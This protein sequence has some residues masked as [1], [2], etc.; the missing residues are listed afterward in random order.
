MAAMEGY[1]KR[2]P[3]ASTRGSALARA[4]LVTVLSLLLLAAAGCG[5]YTELDSREPLKTVHVKV[6]AERTLEPEAVTLDRPGTYAFEVEN[7]TDDDAHALE[8]KSEEGAQINY[9][10]GSVRTEDLSPGAS[11]PR[12]NVHLEA[13]TY[14]ISCPVGSHA[15]EGERGTITVA[16]SQ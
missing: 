14:E 2:S 10:E 5:G 12:F 4:G 9:K 13:G 16:G 6:A 3:G 11:A 8:I 15:E 1:R 7:V